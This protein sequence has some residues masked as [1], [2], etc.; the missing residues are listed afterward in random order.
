MR[1]WGWCGVVQDI[2]ARM[3][4]LLLFFVDAA[5]AIDQEDDDWDLFL[6]VQ[7]HDGVPSIVSRLLPTLAHGMHYSRE[8]MDFIDMLNDVSMP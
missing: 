5:S 1:Q 6:A 8:C 2:H 7:R 3:Q 4:P